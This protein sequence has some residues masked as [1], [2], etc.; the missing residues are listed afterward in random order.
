MSTYSFPVQIRWSDIDANRHMRHSV[1]YDYGATA[2]M[3]ILS[4]R[5]LTTAKLEE[6]QMGPILFREEA[7]F[8]REVLLEDKI[9]IDVVLVKAT[10]DFAR[11]SLRHHI[12]KSDGSIAAIINVDCAWIDMAKRKLTVPNELIRGIVESFPRSDDFQF[13]QLEKKN[14]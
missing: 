8:R 11:W 6:L 12:T 5:G 7:V 3:M 10:P 9:S 14:P 4:E 2:R 13:F 1:Y